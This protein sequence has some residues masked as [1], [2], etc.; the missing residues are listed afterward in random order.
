MQGKLDVVLL[1]IWQQVNIIVALVPAI[2]MVSMDQLCMPAE[3]AQ[4]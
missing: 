1:M 3:L 4:R 2:N